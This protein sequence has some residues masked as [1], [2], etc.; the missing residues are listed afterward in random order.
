M[1]HSNYDYIF[2]LNKYKELFSNYKN[3]FVIDA[4]T[5]YLQIKNIL[6]ILYKRK[7][8]KFYLLIRNIGFNNIFPKFNN[9]FEILNSELFDEE[10]YKDK[11]NLAYENT[12]PAIHYLLIGYKKGFNPGP[13]FNTLDYYEYNQDIEAIGMNPLVH[14]ELNGKNENRIIGPKNDEQSESFL[15]IS[16]S[17][18]F[19]EGWYK[20]T[21][22]ISNEGINPVNHYLKI[23][24][25]KGY[26]PSPNFSTNEYYEVN[27]D[28]KLTGLNPLLH[29]ELIGK[30]ENRFMGSKED[31]DKIYST[32]LNSQYFDKEWYESHYDISKDGLDP[33]IHYLKVGFK[34]GYE[35]GPNFDSEKYYKDNEGVKENGFNP[36]F[37]HEFHE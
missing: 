23:G 26:N 17:E 13:N 19:D 4:E 14:Y 25:K 18:Y 2:V 1:N 28:V 20:E 5:T 22:K 36:L 32:I 15:I 30:N 11:Y 24:Y 12:D 33:V 6:N 7:M 31:K 29:Y 37:F 8:D 27:P 9:Y 16:N 10:W 21:Y 34:K 35:P 3:V